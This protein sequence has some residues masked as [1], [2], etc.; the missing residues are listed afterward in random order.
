MI[1]FTPFQFVSFK[2]NLTMEQA[3][4]TLGRS[5]SLKSE[6]Q[7]SGEVIS[8]NYQPERDVQH[9]SM[10]ALTVYVKY[11]SDPNGVRVKV[12]V[13]P[14]VITMLFLTLTLGFILLF[15]WISLDFSNKIFAIVFWLFIYL[16]NWR[17]A[18]GTKKAIQSMFQDFIIKQ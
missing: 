7:D 8:F 5:L 4:A 6:R 3:I 18:V 2:T 10:G 9:Q 14:T 15:D 16:F 17:Q 11:F 12:T 1:P 13:V